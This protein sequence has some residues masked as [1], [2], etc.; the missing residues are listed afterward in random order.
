MGEPTSEPVNDAPAPPR[1]GPRVIILIPLL[2]AC[3]LLPFVFWKQTWFGEA[4]GAEDIITRIDAISGPNTQQRDLRRAQHAIEQISKR[5][6][7]HAKTGKG[8]P[9]QFYA[10][11]I[12]LAGHEEAVIRETVA[13][14][15]GEDAKEPSF[16]KPLR[17]LVA[18]D[19]PIVRRNAA[20]SLGKRRD[21]AALPVLRAMLLPFPIQAPAAGE[22]VGIVPSVYGVCRGVEIARIRTASGSVETVRTPVL[23]GKTGRVLASKGGTV[24]AGA[25]IC[26]V[27]PSSREVFYAL[28]CLHEIG[29]AAEL[30][31]LKPYLEPSA[32]Y[33][34]KVAE[35]AKRTRVAIEKRT[36]Q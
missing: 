13:W 19:Q 15:M 6:A 27:M 18:D 22:I 12:A 21:L 3:I 17:A 2:V 33:G 10:K 14:L 28:I 30:P 1:K 23:G 32:D 26:S 35:Q 20:L 4:L 36:G 25:I 9:K 24:A 34:R 5:V 31:L 8:D 29:T 11:V 7:T 16:A